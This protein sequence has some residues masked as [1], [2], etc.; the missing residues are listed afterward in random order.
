MVRAVWRD[1]LHDLVA[2]SIDD[3]QRLAFGVQLGEGQVE[4]VEPRPVGQRRSLRRHPVMGDRDHL[5]SQAVEQRY[6]RRL[7]MQGGEFC[8][9][10]VFCAGTLGERLRS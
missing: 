4:R 10:F 1:V 5:A 2:A 8:R 7:G 6:C 9:A 3:P